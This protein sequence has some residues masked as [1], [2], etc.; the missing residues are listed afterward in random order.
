MDS[1][2]INKK[3]LNGK[4]FHKMPDGSWMPGTKHM[5]KGGELEESI[6]SEKGFDYKKIYDASSGTTMYYTKPSRGKNWKDL[7][8]GRNNRSLSAVKAKVFKDDSLKE[9]KEGGDSKEKY[10]P[11]IDEIKKGGYKVKVIA[12]AP[13]KNMPPGHT[14]AI[15]INKDGEPV[16][17][18]YDKDNNK[19]EAFVNRW[20]EGRDE[21]SQFD[22][23]AGWDNRKSLHF[24]SKSQLD[25]KIEKSKYNRAMD[26][27]LDSDQIES[28]LN[29]T[30]LEGGLDY[31]FMENNCAVSQ[32][33]EHL[34]GSIS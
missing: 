20:E 4:P 22:D 17:H 2:S 10:I 3:S 1:K 32:I 6:V 34:L 13:S 7:Q 33:S 30:S 8:D 11:T 23:D 29:S 21:G 27:N 26:L 28:F 24:Q 31:N 5:K 15:L 19:K 9:L 25:D 12:Y 16:T 14:E 18:Y